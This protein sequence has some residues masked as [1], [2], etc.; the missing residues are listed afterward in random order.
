[1]GIIMLTLHDVGSNEKEKGTV[2]PGN[3]NNY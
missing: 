1:V 3:N 2:G